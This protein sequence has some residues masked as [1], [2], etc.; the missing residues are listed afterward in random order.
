[1][2]NSI[3]E[4]E[5]LFFYKTGYNDLDEVLK[6]E[7]LE[8]NKKYIFSW[9]KE[10]HRESINNEDEL[11]IVIKRKDTKEIIGYVLLAGLKG[12]DKSTEFRRI[13]IVQKGKGYGK[14]SINLIKELAFEKLKSHRLWLDV[15]EDNTK[16]INL[17]IK[18]G[19]TVE[20]MLRECKRVEDKYR[21]MMIM[22]I[23]EN[24][25]FD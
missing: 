5:R 11:H 24:E 17:Y 2:G 10:R 15:Y 22:S 7:G 25:Y 18:A 8:D 14:E 12:E 9:S 3:I 4:S 21:S 6:I 16:A 1:M 23:L 20:G 19:F 13:A